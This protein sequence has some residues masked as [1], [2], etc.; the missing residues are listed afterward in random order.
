[1]SDRGQDAGDESEQA[2]LVGL[3]DRVRRRR[4]LV[5]TLEELDLFAH[6][7]V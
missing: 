2:R 5:D 6:H 7:R 3:D 4:E 1:M